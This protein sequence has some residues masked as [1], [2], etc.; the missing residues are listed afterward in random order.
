MLLDL[1]VYGYATGV[2]SSRKIE[3]ACHDSVV[4][5]FIAA[6]TQPDHDSIATFRRRLLAQIA[7]MANVV[8]PLG[9]DEL[10]ALSRSMAHLP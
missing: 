8:Y 1:L 9:D 2:H 3:R 4:F 7:A 5:R 10:R 6:N